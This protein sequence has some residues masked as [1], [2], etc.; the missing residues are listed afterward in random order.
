M[1][2][3]RSSLR[4]DSM[5]RTSLCH[6]RLPIA[7][8]HPPLP[9][10]Q[11]VKHIAFHVI[12]WQYFMWLLYSP[13]ANA[14][15]SLL[16]SSASPTSLLQFLFRGCSSIQTPSVTAMRRQRTAHATSKSHLEPKPNNRSHA[17]HQRPTYRYLAWLVSCPW[18]AAVVR[19]YGRTNLHENDM[20]ASW[21]AAP[22]SRGG[23]V[24]IFAQ[25][26]GVGCA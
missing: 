24:R 14:W 11:I 1:I 6:L 25:D 10:T 9:D 5:L 13:G 19:R 2:L 23:T 21:L 18:H 12:G 4:S 8:H 3:E 17:G 26:R 20:C 22:T 15:C 7:P 16:V